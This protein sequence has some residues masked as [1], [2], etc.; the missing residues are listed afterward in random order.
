GMNDAVFERETVDEWLERRT[1]RARR[2][3]HVDLAGAPLVEIIGGADPREYLA[4][5]VVDD[6]DRGRYVRP[7]SAGALAREIFKRLL[8]RRLEGQAMQLALRRRRNG[9]IGRMGSKDGHGLARDRH[10]LPI[11]ALDLVMTDDAGPGDALEHPPARPARAISGAVRPARRGRLRQRDEQ[12]RLADSEPARLLAEIGERS[13]PHAFEVTAVGGEAEIKRQNLVL[14]QRTFERD[15]AD[16]FAQLYEHAAFAP[17]LQQAG[18]LHGQRRAAGD[19]ATVAQELPG[20]PDERAN[21]DAGM[22]EKALVFVS[23]ERGDVTG[24]DVLDAR[25]Q[26]PTPLARRIG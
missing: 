16:D 21:V 20:R 23:D 7:E 26:A 19:D 25:R 10:R 11:G 6:N 2:R 24:I 18:D 15:C 9:L 3:S 22:L 8:Q 1:G 5:R 14:A 17:R 4:A 12:R 13:R